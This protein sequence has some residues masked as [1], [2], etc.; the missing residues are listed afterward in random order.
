MNYDHIE[1][2][3]RSSKKQYLLSQLEPK[4]QW[5]SLLIHISLEQK[6]FML[7]I[8]KKF[9]LMSSN[10]MLALMYTDAIA[11]APSRPSSVLRLGFYGSTQ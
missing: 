9:R 10:D 3:T 11:Q 8:V 4:A 6:C 1:L 5:F 2:K 7:V